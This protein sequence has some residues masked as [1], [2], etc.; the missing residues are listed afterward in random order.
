MQDDEPSEQM[1]EQQTGEQQEHSD[2]E[3][4]MT[5][6]PDLPQVLKEVP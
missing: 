4:K 5:E 6:E 2:P 3:V 1:D